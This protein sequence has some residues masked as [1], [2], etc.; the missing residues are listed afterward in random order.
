[1]QHLAQVVAGLG[2]ARIGPEQKREVL[3]QLRRVAM[4]HQ[5][6]EQRMQPWSVDAGDRLVTV[7]QAE[8]TKQSYM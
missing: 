1:M 7:D 4:Q 5:V 3:A 2:F 6:G 8:I